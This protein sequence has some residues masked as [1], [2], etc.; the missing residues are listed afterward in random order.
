MLEHVVARLRD[1]SEAGFN[2]AVS[3]VYDSFNLLEAIEDEWQDKPSLPAD[4]VDPGDAEQGGDDVGH[5]PNGFV[6]GGV[7]LADG[8][9]AVGHVVAQLLGVIP[10]DPLGVFAPLLI[11]GH[12]DRVEPVGGVLGADLAE[13]VFD[14]IGRET[15]YAAAAPGRS[16]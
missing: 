6:G 14:E 7:D 4:R 10:L 15:A 13:H 16:G 8:V 9:A 2:L 3:V 11:G 5:S 12:T 1:G